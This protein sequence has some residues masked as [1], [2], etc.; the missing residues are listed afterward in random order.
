M[1][2][3]LSNRIVPSWNHGILYLMLLSYYVFV[4]FHPERNEGSQGSKE[5]WTLSHPVKLQ[6]C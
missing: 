5:L 4:D 3:N 1:T 6:R 2:E